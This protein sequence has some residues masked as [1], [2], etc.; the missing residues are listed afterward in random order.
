MLSRKQSMLEEEVKKE[1]V[2]NK[3]D[4]QVADDMMN[5]LEAMMNPEPKANRS[6]PTHSYLPNLCFALI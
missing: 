5:E 4:Q 1:S 3:A 2:K 6:P